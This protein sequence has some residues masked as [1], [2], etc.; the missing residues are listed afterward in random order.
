MSRTQTTILSLTLLAVL[1]TSGCTLND[2]FAT[3]GSGGQVA[4]RGGYA[5]LTEGDR[6]GE[7]F[8]DTLN[9]GDANDGD[10]G[11]NIGAHLDVP[12]LEDPNQNRILGEIAL[13]YQQF[14]REEVVV[15]GDVITDT[16]GATPPPPVVDEVTVNEM[17]ISVSPK[18]RLDSM[19]K[20]RPWIIPAGLS[21]L[22]TSPPSDR[23]T[24]LDVGMNF[25]AGADVRLTDYLSVGAD[26]RYI[27]G[28]GASDAS[29]DVFS[30]GGYLGID[31]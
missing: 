25:G 28:F 12:L 24:Y 9:T 1:T 30:T 16:L 11:F 15:V 17:T 8:T 19:G 22:V 14:S 20:I 18:Y 29:N 23:S 2:L 31:F 6:G 10:D 3:K 5:L 26:A 13:D 27:V 7:L 21:F 4:F